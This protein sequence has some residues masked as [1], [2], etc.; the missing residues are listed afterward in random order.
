MRQSSNL[1]STGFF[2]RLKGGSDHDPPCLFDI[3]LISV[4]LPH[5][6]GL[7]F[8]LFYH[9]GCSRIFGIYSR[10][11]EPSR[12]SLDNLAHSRVV[13]IASA[14]VF[15]LFKVE[16]FVIRNYVDVISHNYSSF[17]SQLFYSYIITYHRRCKNKQIVNSPRIIAK[18]CSLFMCI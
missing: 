3:I 1:V 16:L 17:S 7:S 18:F 6:M 13:S 4:R 15:E 9:R 2:Y 14:D 8:V 10:Y 11:K 5:W 12:H